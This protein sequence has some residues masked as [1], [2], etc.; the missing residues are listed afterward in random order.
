LK[1]AHPRQLPPEK[2]APPKTPVSVRFDDWELTGT[3]DQYSSLIARR[4]GHNSRQ[5]LLI[6]T[7]QHEGP[8]FK[9]VSPCR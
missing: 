6:F 8:V 1:T 7:V 9:E 5:V 3:M 4:G 2:T